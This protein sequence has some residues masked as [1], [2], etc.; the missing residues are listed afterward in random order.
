MF[1]QTVERLNQAVHI[2]TTR[3]EQAQAVQR[4]GD[5]AGRDEREAVLAKRLS[6]LER[7]A[8]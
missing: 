5:R 6:A 4:H 7:Q 2:L 1:E 3:R 8:R